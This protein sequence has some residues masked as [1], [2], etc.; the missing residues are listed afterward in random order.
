MSFLRASAACARVCSLR[1]SAASFGCVSARVASASASVSSRPFSS[2][3]LLASDGGAPLVG[4]STFALA[5]VVAPEGLVGIVRAVDAHT[6]VALAWTHPDF[7]GHGLA[8]YCAQ[9]AVRTC[10]NEQR[11]VWYVVDEQN[12]PSIRVIEK[13][14]GTLRET[15]SLGASQPRKRHYT[16][17]VP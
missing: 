3:R 17:R 5:A 9:E 10:L 8:T 16:I 12:L 14:G 11:S 6:S 15:R 4:A 7:R 2:R 13:N 1:S